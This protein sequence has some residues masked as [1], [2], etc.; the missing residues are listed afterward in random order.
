MSHDITPD[1]H[2][3]GDG[4]AHLTNLCGEV[5]PSVLLEAVKTYL[6]NNA[7][8]ADLC[9]FACVLRDSTELNKAHAEAVHS[10][11]QIEA[12]GPQ[13]STV[14]EHVPAFEDSFNGPTTGEHGRHTVTCADCRSPHAVLWIEDETSRLPDHCGCWADCPTCDTINGIEGRCGCDIGA[15]VVWTVAFTVPEGVDIG[16]LSGRVELEFGSEAAAEAWVREHLEPVEVGCMI[17]DGVKA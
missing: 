15:A 17:W 3:T 10:L 16:G 9:Y 8:P 13:T 14:Q 1:Q 12:N 2:P 7:T 11:L 6:H 4:I 5:A